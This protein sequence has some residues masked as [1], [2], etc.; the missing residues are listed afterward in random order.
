MYTALSR[1]GALIPFKEAAPDTPPP[2]RPR[3]VMSEAAKRGRN[4]AVFTVV[5]LGGTL[6]AAAAGSAVSIV[7]LLILA[8]VS[9]VLG[10]RAALDAAAG[11]WTTAVTDP[12]ELVRPWDPDSWYVRHAAAYYHRRYVVPRTDMDSDAREVWSR[13]IAAANTIGSAEVVRQRLVD[14]VQVAAAMPQR[15]WEIAEASPG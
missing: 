13:A 14:S 2:P 6:M 11:G 12:E 10:I 1:R 4:S 3:R 5:F 7:L 15:L 8:G 9:A